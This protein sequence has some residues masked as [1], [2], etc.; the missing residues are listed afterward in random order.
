MGADEAIGG[1]PEYYNFFYIYSA[2]RYCIDMTIKIDISY[3]EFL[4]KLSILEIKS[5]HITD[6]KQARNVNKELSLLQELWAADPQS[7]VDIVKELA[8]LKSINEKLWGIEDDIRE[9]ERQK[10]FDDE[11]VRL[12]R[13]VYYINDDRAAVKRVLN[14]KL[15]SILIEEKSYADYK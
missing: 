7:G 10:A 1:Y 6:E 14:E 13:A 3:G 9:K 12:A 15:G 8:K 5:E 4:D 11:F 2:T